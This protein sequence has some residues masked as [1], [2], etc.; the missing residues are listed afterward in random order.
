MIEIAN[1]TPDGISNDES[2]ETI[3]AYVDALNWACLGFTRKTIHLKN[4]HV[5]NALKYK[6]LTFSCK[7]GNE[8]E[9]VSETVLAAGDT[10]QFI[11]NYVYAQVKVQV[12]SSVGGSPAAFLVDFTGNR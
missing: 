10:A 6:L 2:G 3:N 7:S 12:K 4:T 8:Y 5:A 11:L 1:N 9:E